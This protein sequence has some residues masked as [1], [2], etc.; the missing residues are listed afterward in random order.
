MF[1]QTS[2]RVRFELRVLL[3]NKKKKVKKET[4][5]KILDGAW[6]DTSVGNS[7]QLTYTT[8]PQSV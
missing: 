1:I 7:T 6:R 8:S 5:K 4:K 2:K 3:G